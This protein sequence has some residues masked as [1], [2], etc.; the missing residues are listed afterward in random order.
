MDSGTKTLRKM[1]A[2]ATTSDGAESLQAMAADCF[3]TAIGKAGRALFDVKAELADPEQV[4]LFLAELLASVKGPGLL[5][6]FEIASQCKG[7]LSLDGLLVNALVELSVGASERSVLKDEREP[8]LIDAALCRE[9]CECL[10][11]LFP[12]EL[13]KAAGKPVLPTLSYCRHEVDPGKL[14]FELA[15]GRHAKISGQIQ[16]QGG[17]RGGGFVISL[18]LDAWNAPKNTERTAP[19]PVW[20]SALEENVAGAPLVMQ[21]NLET[22]PLPLG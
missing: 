16:F 2:R 6:T 15:Q 10:L 18:P 3:A 4:D 8:T 1:I 9:F 19:D 14:A 12:G 22:L 11:D 5:V 21:A 17:L 13:T 20:S 7:L